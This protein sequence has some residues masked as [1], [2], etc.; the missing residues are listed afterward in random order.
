MGDQLGDTR[1]GEG[2]RTELVGVELLDVAL[3]EAK[4]GGVR[5]V[6]GHVPSAGEIVRFLREGQVVLHLH[7]EVN[8]FTIEPSLSCTSV[9]SGQ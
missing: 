1:R 4:A 7:G 3:L 8:A 6:A 5:D 9:R 2:G